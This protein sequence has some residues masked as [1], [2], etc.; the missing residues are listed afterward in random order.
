MG[1][2]VRTVRWW[3]ETVLRELGVSGGVT[4]NVDAV[5]DGDDVWGGRVDTGAAGFA[6]RLRLDGPAGPDPVGDGVMVRIEFP[7]GSAT[8]VL[9]SPLSQE[10]DAVAQLADQLQD[11]VLESTGGAPVPRCPVAG[12]GHP[13]VAEVVDGAACWTC[14]SGGPIRPVLPDTRRS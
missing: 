10:A 5:R 8:G 2:E 7:D 11:A 3:A 9:L 1:P 6:S 13:A 12:H 4:L 14:P